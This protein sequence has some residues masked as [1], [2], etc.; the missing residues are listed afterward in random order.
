MT[1]NMDDEADKLKNEV[2]SPDSCHSLTGYD[3][4]YIPKNSRDFE[5]HLDKKHGGR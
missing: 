4:N 5:K 2:F 1:K 3:C